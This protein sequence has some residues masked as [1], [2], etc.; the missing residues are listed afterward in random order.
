MTF[1]ILCYFE[2]F[3]SFRSGEVPV[4]NVLWFPQTYIHNNSTNIAHVPFLENDNLVHLTFLGPANKKLSAVKKQGIQHVVQFLADTNFQPKQL[5]SDILLWW[6]HFF[7]KE[8]IPKWKGRLQIQIDVFY[9]TATRSKGIT[10]LVV[11]ILWKLILLVTLKLITESIIT[12]ENSG[13][14][15]II[16]LTTLGMILISCASF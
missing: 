1:D 11:N 6:N 15:C 16:A 3:I 8:L 12:S 10:G 5:S 4:I 2:C 14:A 7:I 9:C 13:L